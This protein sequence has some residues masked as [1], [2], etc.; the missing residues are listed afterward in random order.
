MKQYLIE[1]DLLDFR[2]AV[3]QKQIIERKFAK[4]NDKDKILSI[5]NYVRDEVLFGY[6]ISD[7]RS[8]SEVLNDGYGQCNTKGIL[9]MSLLRAV[10]VPCRMHGFTIDKILQKGAITGIAYLLSPKEILHS[11]VEVYYDN[12][13][14]N[15]EGFILDVKYLSKLQSKFKDCSGSFCGYGVA[16]KD[17]KNPQIYWD[18]DD[19]YIQKEGIVKDYGIYNSPDDLLKEHKQDLNFMKRWLFENVVRHLMNKNVRKIRN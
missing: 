15:I 2:S 5:Y 17:F 19:T 11:W 18:G 6:N 3:I 13:W 9:F 10:G 16:T 7:N 8:S 4:L 12:K 14:R 1:T